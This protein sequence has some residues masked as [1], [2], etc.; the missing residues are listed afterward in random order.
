MTL[1]RR[2]ALKLGGLSVLGVGALG[3]PIGA[4]AQTKA[5]SRLSDA[6]F[7]KRYAV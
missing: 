6:N 1:S 5:A 4:G 7:P 3:V 2:D